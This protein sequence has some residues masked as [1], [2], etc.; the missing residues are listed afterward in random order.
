M[1]IGSAVW[2]L[3]AAVP[4]VAHAD[5][6]SF[7]MCPEYPAPLTNTPDHDSNNL[8]PT[9]SG[10][11]QVRTW[12]QAT[13]GGWHRILVST[14]DG[15]RMFSMSGSDATGPFILNTW[16]TTG[17]QLTGTT[18]TSVTVV[19]A[20]DRSATSSGV[21]V[22]VANAPG[23]QPTEI[24]YVNANTPFLTLPPCKNESSV[25]AG[26]TG[27]AVQGNLAFATN[28]CLAADHHFV[29]GSVDV[30]HLNGSSPPTMAQRIYVDG[31]P[32]AVDFSK[33]GQY[34]YVTNE[35]AGPKALQMTGQSGSGGLK[36]VGALMV[37]A[38]HPAGGSSGFL[39]DVTAVNPGCTPSRV[40]VDLGGRVWVSARGSNEI[41]IFSPSALISNPAASK[42]A[43]L[44]TG[45]QPGAMKLVDGGAAMA[46]MNTF[47]ENNLDKYDNYPPPSVML[48]RTTGY[49]TSTP[50]TPQIRP[51]CNTWGTP[52]VPGNETDICS[53]GHEG[54]APCD[55]G[56]FPRNF[57]LD[58]EHLFYTLWGADKVQFRSVSFIHTR[59]QACPP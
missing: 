3:V 34:L 27:I 29:Q 42:L 28:E 44:K 13:T 10:P 50:N 38:I 5:D 57:G 55:D 35:I 1:R 24:G 6:T 15:M 32:V 43:R 58:D 7:A 46:V 45:P 51:S 14:K 25:G 49:S 48:F 9:P 56:D 37:F 52:G 8:V 2:L 33:D 16:S 39:S 59:V 40:E 53:N 54:Y 31:A 36:P 41:S 23:E 17:F 18:P 21:H 11:N 30:I 47:R 22:Y 12:R 26:T 20:E 19:A 4:L